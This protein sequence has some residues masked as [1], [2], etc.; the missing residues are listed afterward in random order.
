MFFC[1]AISDHSTPSLNDYP[2]FKLLLVICFRDP[3]FRPSIHTRNVSLSRSHNQQLAFTR[4]LWLSYTRFPHSSLLL[5]LA[6][7]RQ[8]LNNS[9]ILPPQPSPTRCMF[10]QILSHPRPNYRLI[11]QTLQ[12]HPFSFSSAFRPLMSN[13]ANHN[14]A[15]TAQNSDVLDNYVQNYI[16]YQSKTALQAMLLLNSA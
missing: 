2:S 15:I 9:H 1:T 4:N 5:N 11:P 14:S 10:F 6:S 13:K 16:A 7:S 12:K 3:A 8:A